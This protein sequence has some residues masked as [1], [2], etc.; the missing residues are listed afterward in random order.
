MYHT[1]TL[2]HDG[3]VCEAG[4]VMDLSKVVNVA[5]GGVLTTVGIVFTQTHVEY[6]VSQAT[7]NLKQDAYSYNVR[8]CTHIYMHMHNVMWWKHGIYKCKKHFIKMLK[9][10]RMEVPKIKENKI[11]HTRQSNGR[12]IT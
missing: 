3:L 8:T 5:D 12:L 1:C 6:P 10:V 2:S 11:M 7:V 4:H 9:D